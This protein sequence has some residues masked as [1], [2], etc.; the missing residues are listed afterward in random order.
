[1]VWHDG[2]D[3]SYEEARR[4]RLGSEADRPH[5]LRYRKLTRV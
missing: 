5:R 1:M 4:R 3:T 2:N